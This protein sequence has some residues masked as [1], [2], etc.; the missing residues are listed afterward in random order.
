M[1]QLICGQ[2]EG[3]GDAAACRFHLDVVGRPVQQKGADIVPGAVAQ[4]TW[5][6][7]NPLGEVRAAMCREPCTFMLDNQAFT[8][9]PD[10][11]VARLT[12]E[13][14]DSRPL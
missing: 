5:N 1:A 9:E 10:I 4:R 7:D 3:H 8:L 6:V 11:S 2:K 12:L 14:V 13:I